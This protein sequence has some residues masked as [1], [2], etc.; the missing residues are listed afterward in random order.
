MIRLCLLPSVARGGL[1]FGSKARG[2]RVIGLLSL[3]G[4]LL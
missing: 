4:G 1:F 3:P 2:F